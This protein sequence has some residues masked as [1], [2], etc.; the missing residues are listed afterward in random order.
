MPNSTKVFANQY[1]ECPRSRLLRTNA[2]QYH[3]ME[4]DRQDADIDIATPSNGWRL[5]DLFSRLKALRFSDHASHLNPG[6]RPS[7]PPP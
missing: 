6:L 4:V 7:G 5:Y 2:I 1:W 3:V